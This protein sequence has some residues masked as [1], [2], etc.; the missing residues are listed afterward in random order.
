MALLWFDGFEAKDCTLYEESSIFSPEV[1]V[2]RTRYAHGWGVYFGNSGN[3]YISKRVTSSATLIAGCAYN[4]VNT[5]ANFMMGFIGDAGATN[6][7][8][9]NSTATGGINITLGGSTVLASSANGVIPAN[10]TWFYMECKVT[11]ADSG[12]S[13]EVRINGNSTPVVTFTGDTKNGGTAAVLDTVRVYTHSANHVVDDFY[14][15]DTTGSAPHN[16]FL[17]NVMVQTSFPE[18]PGASTNLAS[19]GSNWDAQNDTGTSPTADYTESATSGARDTYDMQTF[20]TQYGSTVFGVRS[21][22]WLSKSDAGFVQAKAALKVGSN[23]YYGVTRQP[24]ATALRYW[25]IFSTSPAT[26]SAWTVS[27]INALEMGMEVV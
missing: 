20:N 21:N 27:E 11:L 19:A 6:H 10:G 18:G 26:S 23:V 4:W 15:C 13:V 24:I 25:D 12:G 9:I 8:V 22:L 14:V 17:G 7:I 2:A 3:R 1:Y 16:T 5:A